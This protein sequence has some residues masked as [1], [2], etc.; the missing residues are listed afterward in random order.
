[1]AASAPATAQAAAAHTFTRAVHVVF[2]EWTCLKLAVE[3]EWGGRQS[4]EKGLALLKR[5]LDGLLGSANVHRDELEDLLDLAL[6][7]DFNIETEDS[8]PREV[9]ELLVRLHAEAKA[10]GTTTAD[11]LLLRAAGKGSSWVEVPPPPKAHDESSDDDDDCDD[12]DGDGSTPR[13][14]GPSAMEAEDVS[15]ADGGASKAPVVD[16][17]GFTMVATRKR[18]GRR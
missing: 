2:G 7:D 16:E 17:D 6:L 10:G 9:A 1:M 15:D 18:G 14:G 8:S 3:N 13:A 5:V 12:D 4:R 11:A